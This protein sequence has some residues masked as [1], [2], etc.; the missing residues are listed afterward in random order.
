MIN[1]FE[2]RKKVLSHA[3]SLS[4]FRLPFTDALGFVLAEDIHTKENIPRFDFSAVD[5][6]AVNSR[7][8]LNVTNKKPVAL[9]L[10]GTIQA[11]DSTIAALRPQ[12]AMKILTGAPIPK[13]TDA[14]VMQEFVE[15]DNNQIRFFHSI[16]SGENI[17]RAGQEFQKGKIVLPNGA[18]INPPIIG[19]L[20]TIGK[21]TVRVYR[22]PRVAI[23]VT[24]NELVSPSAR[25]SRGKIRDANSST[26]AS[27]LMR[28]GITPVF[29]ARVQDDITATQK[30]I[31]S[32]LNKSDV[33]LTVGGV[34][35][36]E[37]DFVKTALEHLNVSPVFWR[38]AIKPGKPNFFGTKGK[39]LVFGL[40]G[41]PVA[42]LV[43]FELFV[44]PALRKMMG[45]TITEPMQLKATLSVS[46][47]KKAGRM[48]FVRGV[49]STNENG[50]FVIPAKG[51]ESHM[52]GGLA[53]AN[54]LIHF[55]QDEEYIPEGN[56][57]TITVLHW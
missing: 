20:A 3:V 52:L 38:V 17:R 55:P 21:T 19:L 42:V 41:N 14:V 4:S 44:K 12:M 11:G 33:V 13:N 37:Y 23:I 15:Q 53:V 31:A 45:Y 29:S 8:L 7:D 30:A 6:F 36:G 27:A 48:E 51:Q 34:S 25:I 49:F 47:R 50:V 18:V 57:V 24:G 40:P 39:K 16:E 56:V 28:L 10:L 22:K 26:L 32:A 9:S 46:L 43:S 54:C 5:G 35:V 2:A 1:F